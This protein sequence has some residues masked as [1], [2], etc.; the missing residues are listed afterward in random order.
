MVEDGNMARWLICGAFAGLAVDIGLYPLDTIKSRMQSEKGFLASG[1]FRN[2]YRGMSS[3]LVGSAP[4]ASIF[5]ISYKYINTQ[6]R[7]KFHTNE[8]AIDALS[9]SVAEIAACAIRVPTELCKQRAQ[10]AANSRLTL[11]CKEIY[12]A[13]GLVG[14]YQGY[15]STIAREI[16]FSM[17]QFPIWEGLKR[18]VAKKSDTGVCNPLMGAICGSIAGCISAGLTTPLDVAKTRIML[19]K[20]GPEPK[21]LATLKEVYTTNGLAGLF[22]GV[23]PRMMWI[24]GG[25]FVFFGA[26]E[27]AIPIFS[28]TKTDSL[29]HAP[30]YKTFLHRTRFIILVYITIFNTII[31][32]NSISINTASICRI[33]FPENSTN[34]DSFDIDDFPFDGNTY[35]FNQQLFLISVSSIGTLLAYYPIFAISLGCCSASVFQLIPCVISKWSTRKREYLCFLM[36]STFFQFSYSLIS[37]ISGYLCNSWIGWASIF[38]I[39]AIA[40]IFAS[41]LFFYF[42]KYIMLILAILSIISNLVFQFFFRFEK[43]DWQRCDTVAPCRP[44]QIAPVSH[45]RPCEFTASFNNDIVVSVITPALERCDT[46]KKHGIHTSREIAKEDDEL[47]SIIRM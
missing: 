16:P 24:S 45:P 12:R 10:V 15:G 28:A 25:G 41:I 23:A 11:I 33:V 2:V 21:I 43:S 38:Y 37:P 30:A 4:G 20:T 3:V 29:R 19:T 34:S 27:M 1:G 5:F 40:S 6:M 14:F 7:K 31:Y 39:Q 36:L 22:S 17:I 9:A 32:T 46:C 18:C 42:Y 47:V 13:K 8:A 35:S 44:E 26:Y